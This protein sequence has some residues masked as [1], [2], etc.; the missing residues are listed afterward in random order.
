MG[1]NMIQTAIKKWRRKD[2][3]KLSPEAK[4]FQLPYKKL[5]FWQQQRQI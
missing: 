4:V 1:M 5:C 3:L 2:I